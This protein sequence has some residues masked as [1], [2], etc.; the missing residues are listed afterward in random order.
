MPVLIGTIDG[1]PVAGW[2]NEYY[3]R[4]MDLESFAKPGEPAIVARFVTEQFLES[5]QAVEVEIL[6]FGR[7]RGAIIDDI[8]PAPGANRRGGMNC[9]QFQSNYNPEPDPAAIDP[10]ILRLPA[11]EVLRD[12]GLD[13]VAEKVLRI[14]AMLGVDVDGPTATQEGGER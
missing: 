11:C 12:A 10:D 2:Y 13:E 8:T 9:Y 3:F 6:G 4:S 7:L 5:D 1:R 14:A